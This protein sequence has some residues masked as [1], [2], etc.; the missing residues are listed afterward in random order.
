MNA[1]L[2]KL[3]GSDLRS[4][5]RANEVAEEVTRN[6]Q[7]LNQLLEGLTEPDDVIRARTAHALER[8]PRKNQ[9]VFRGLMT[10][11]VGLAVTDKIPMV[12]WHLAMI[13]GNTAFA[14]GD[15][16]RVVSTLIGLLKDES[17]FVRSW[18]ISSLCIIG[19]RNK[20]R[21]TKIIDA[22]KALQHDKTGAIRVSAAKAL[23]MLQNE[24]EPLP[25]GWCKT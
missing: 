24:N 9:E 11:L 10:R 13:F 1:L 21:R 2:R 16:E 12:R 23:T 19:R 20:P 4:D 18:T 15:I 7:L 8:V 5:G 3:S 22:I 6:P 14:A 25:A 17:V